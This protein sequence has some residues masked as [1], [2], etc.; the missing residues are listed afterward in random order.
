MGKRKAFTL[1]ELLVVI[2]IIAILA[3]ILF[4]VFAQAR[5]AAKKTAAISNQKQI[6]LGLLMYLS[7]YD[8]K[9]PRNDDC[10]QG[11]SLNPALRNR[12]GGCNGPFFN[13]MNHFSWQKWVLPYVKSVNLFFHPGRQRFDDATTC[14]GG[15]RC[16]TDDG[17]IM[18][19]YALNTS[20]TGMLNTFS[21]IQGGSFRDSWLGGRSTAIPRPA[22]TMILFE[23][24]H[25]RINFVPVAVQ[26]GDRS[27]NVVAYPPAWRNMWKRTWFSWTRCNNIDDEGGY[28]GNSPDPNILFANGVVVGFSDGSA[29]FLQANDVV[30]RMP[31]RQEYRAIP[32]ENQCG[33]G[34][35]A[36]GVTTYTNTPNVDIDYPFWGLGL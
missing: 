18:G 21:G 23:Y 22:E 5:V 32:V 9:Y 14:T 2:A 13:R 26:S 20:I 25:P 35:N 24:T 19:G 11:S 34:L 16:W 27:I 29:K 17:Q 12:S 3:A 1:I 6:S 4:P 7:D 31:T 28:R 30:R 8:D 15:R 33:F 10:V 36:G